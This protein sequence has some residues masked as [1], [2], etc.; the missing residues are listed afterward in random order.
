MP[1]YVQVRILQEEFEDLPAME[2]ACREMGLKLEN[3]NGR[4]WIGGSIQVTQRGK[5]YIM[6]TS[7]GTMLGKLMDEYAAAK[8]TREAKRRNMEV[9][10]EK[11]KDGTITLKVYQ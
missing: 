8:I 11:A 6:E 4:I 5:K 9:K 2:A 10:R 1:C 7:N 3:R